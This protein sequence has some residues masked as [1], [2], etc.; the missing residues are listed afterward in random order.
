[1]DVYPVDGNHAIDTIKRYGDRAISSDESI[2]KK[3]T[4][5]MQSLPPSTRSGP[6]SMLTGRLQVK[7]ATTGRRAAHC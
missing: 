2:Q 3:H 6:A 4:L 1:M 5:S 7:T